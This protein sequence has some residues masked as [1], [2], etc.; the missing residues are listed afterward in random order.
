MKT[1][2][3]LTILALSSTLFAQQQPWSKYQ[4]H[5]ENRPHPQKV[6]AKT[7][8]TTPAPAD[9]DVIF[10][11]T[12]THALTKNWSIAD[13]KLV[14]NRKGDTQT[15]K[16]YGD[17]QIHLEWRIPAGRNVKGQLG[18]NSGIFMMNLYEIQIQESFRNVTYADGQAGAIYGQTPPL[19]NASRPQGEWQSYDIFF[20]APVYKDGKLVTPAYVTVLHNGILVQNNQHFYGPTV[21]KKV[22]KYPTSH[23]AKAPIRLQW[24]G[25]PVEFKNF[26]VRDLSNKK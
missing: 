4:V 12:N 26:W 21:Y 3:P 5:D 14:A 23:P 18:G 22:A 9:A 6:E 10:D 25:D 20:K 24:H 13:G 15:K 19:V 16:S 17:C 1:L 7:F 11:G 2:I 8:L